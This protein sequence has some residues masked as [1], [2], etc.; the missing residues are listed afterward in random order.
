MDLWQSTHEHFR[1]GDVRAAVLELEQYL[2]GTD[3]QSFSSLIGA[4]FTNNKGEVLAILN[5]FLEQANS[6]FD[7]KAIYVEMNGFD[8]NYHRWYFDLFA[9]S[10]YDNDFDDNDWLCDW[11]PSPSDEVELEGMSLA[12]SA[13]AWY[14]TKRIWKSQRDFKPTYEAAMLL[15]MAT[16]CLF[17]EEVVSSGALIKNIPV[18]VTAHGFD[19]VARFNLGEPGPAG[20]R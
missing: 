14:H 11:Q 13:F 7:V 6:E 12:Q 20:D 17:M 3:A 15:T 9:Y 16:F 18:L 10:S 19:S 1:R 5:Q 8:I 4:R 2:A